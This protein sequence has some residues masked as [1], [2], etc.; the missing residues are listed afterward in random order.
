MKLIRLAE[1]FEPHYGVNLALN[2]MVPV[3]DG[4][5]FVSRTAKDNGVSARVERIK[6]VTP[7]PAH[8]LSVAAGGSV[9]A[10]F[11]QPWPY[12][13]GRDVYVLVSLQTI[14]VKEMLIYAT[15]ISANSY[16]YNY[17]RQANRTLDSLMIPEKK[18]VETVCDRIFS[19]ERSTSFACPDWAFIERYLKSPPV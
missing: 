4:I 9:L 8:T 16:K 18:A 6:G 13:S 7:N 19:P 2:A 12:Y 17:G 11:Y 5:P 1:M 15:M 14:S 3:T 10:T